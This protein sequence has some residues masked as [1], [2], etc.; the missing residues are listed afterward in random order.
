MC[1][2]TKRV[3]ENQ[4]VRDAGAFEVLLTAAHAG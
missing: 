2:N 3:M 1:I 4:P